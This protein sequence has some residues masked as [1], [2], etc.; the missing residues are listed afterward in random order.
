MHSIELRD[1][2][3]EGRR[4]LIVLLAAHEASEVASR[5]PTA[6]PGPQRQYHQVET[7]AE[8]SMFCRTYIARNRLDGKMWAGGDIMEDGEIIGRVAHSGRVWAAIPATVRRVATR[9][10][11]L[12][13]EHVGPE[14]MREI[15]RRN[16]A[17][18]A[19]CVCHAHDFTDANMLMLE[20]MSGVVGRH[21]DDDSPAM[22]WLFDVAW[23]HARMNWLDLAECG[24]PRYLLVVRGD[25]Q[26]ELHGPYQN[27]ASRELA[28]HG[29]RLEVA[30]LPSAL[31]RADA[32]AGRA[33]LSPA[34][35]AAGEGRSSGVTPCHPDLRQNARAVS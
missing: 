10:S 18:T 7:L 31:F 26:L 1:I 8:A 22:M 24:T 17:E 6:T 2:P 32:I 20:A 13:L 4:N 35:W 21:V 9:F 5:Q 19:A 15:A 27:E 29:I 25:A 23:Q 14:H 12:L 33:V 11:E 34:Y 30:E 28:A 16:A 3:G